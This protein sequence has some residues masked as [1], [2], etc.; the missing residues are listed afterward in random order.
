MDNLLSA[1]KSIEGEL[2]CMSMQELD[3]IHNMLVQSLLR[4][5]DK[6]EEA[7][8]P[9]ACANI[10]ARNG[11]IDFA[12]LKDEME[13]VLEITTKARI[14]NLETTITQLGGDDEIAEGPKLLTGGEVR[15]VLD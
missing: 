7:A 12:A 8:I 6:V 14:A 9:V 13:R 2:D 15:V 1:L 5:F 3:G 10:Y 11:A 4:H